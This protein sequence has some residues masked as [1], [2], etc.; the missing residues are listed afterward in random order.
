MKKLLPI[1]LM[2]IAAFAALPASADELIVCDG[3]VENQYLPTY[4]LYWDTHVRSQMIYPASM[5]TELQG[6]DITALSYFL[7]SVSKEL[8]V[9]SA[10]FRIGPSP[11]ASWVRDSYENNWISSDGLITVSSQRTVL[12]EQST[13]WRV[14]FTTPYTYTGG[15]MVVEIELEPDSPPVYGTIYSYGITTENP[16]SAYANSWT[17]GPV[18]PCYLPKT[19]FEYAASTVDGVEDIE[20]ADTDVAAEFYTLQGVRVNPETAAPGIYVKRQGSKTSKVVVR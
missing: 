2:A 20:A 12:N 16:Q 14:E 1:G 8:S 3:I 15:D 6:K 18:C 5:L 19:K 9:A 7:K 17:S 11:R 4:G 10:T 13:N